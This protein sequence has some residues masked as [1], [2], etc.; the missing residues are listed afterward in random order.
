MSQ[1]K[2]LSFPSTDGVNTVAATLWEPDEP[3]RAVLQV[4]HGMG[5]H[6]GR[7]RWF[8][9]QMTSRGIAVAGD[10]HLGHGRTASG[11]EELGYFGARDGYV[12]LMED[13]HSLRRELEKRYP[14]LPCFL[15]GHSMGSFITRFYVSRHGEGLAGYLCCGTSG[16]NPLVK[17]AILLSNLLV[18]VQ[19]GKTR[20]SLLNKLAFQ[21]YNKR[22][23][24]AAT[25]HEWLSRDPEVYLPFENDP[26][27]G[28]VFTNA[29]FRDLFRLL[30]TVTGRKWSDRVPRDL[31]V[32]LLSG[33]EDPVGQYGK[34]V[35]QVY[36]WLKESGVRDLSIRLY[37]GARHELHNE[38]NRD[39]FV[40]DVAAWMEKRM[41]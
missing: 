20:G 6:I 22:F 13:E 5:E 17:A 34:G 4:C 8:A 1:S 3:P 31:P 24:P 39:E 15:L 11:A 26:Y 10:D 9:E 14:G 36:A 27:C 2:E 38:L 21:D 37:P 35:R 29:G 30:D 28:F 19:G 33:E 41:G 32:I 25:G 16:R 12:H 23:A 18:G 40:A 7:Y